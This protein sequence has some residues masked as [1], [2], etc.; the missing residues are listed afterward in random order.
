MTMSVTTRLYTAEDLAALG[1]DSHFELIRG[2]LREKV[3]AKLRH[4]KVVGRF[5]TFLG[6]YS[7]NVLPGEVING[8]TGFHLEADPDSVIMPD[9]SFI[10]R[11]RMPGDDAL[12]SFARVAPDAVVEVRSPSNTRRD[13][14]MKIVIYLGAG[15]RLVLVADALTKEIEAHGADGS[16]RVYRVGDDL[17]GGDVLPGFLVPVAAF[18][19]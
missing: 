19:D 12:D 17:D 2:E 9:V 11:D 4:G 13:I 18:F 16:V 8:E 10:R 5:H 14:K 3:A 1:D 15:V 7:L 6:M